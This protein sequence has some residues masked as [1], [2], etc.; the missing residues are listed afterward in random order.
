MF[1]FQPLEITFVVRLLTPDDG[2]QTLHKLYTAKCANAL[3]C[4]KT[5]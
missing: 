4:V 1:F 2:A 5:F 3:E